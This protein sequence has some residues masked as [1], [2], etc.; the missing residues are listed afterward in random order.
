MASLLVTIDPLNDGKINFSGNFR[1]YTNDEPISNVVSITD[2]LEDV[3]FGDNDPNL[4]KRFFRYSKDGDTWSMWYDWEPFS[5]PELGII[6]LLAFNPDDSLY[7]S[8]KYLYDDGSHDVLLTPIEINEINLKLNLKVTKVPLNLNSIKPKVSCTPEHCPD[9]L[10]DRHSSFD[11]YDIGNLGD[12]YK[13]MSYSINEFGGLPVLYFQTTPNASG[14]DFIFREYTLYDVLDR[15][16]VKVV[17][18]KNE[19]PTADFRFV[20]NGQEYSGPFEVSID[21]LYFETYFGRGKEPRKKDF[22]YFPLLN[23]MYEIQDVSMFR[24]FMMIPIYWKIILTKFQ[25]NINYNLGEQNSKFLDNILLNS[26]NQFGTEAKKQEL[27]VLMEQQNSTISEKYDEVRS[28]IDT[29]MFI[30]E[31]ELNYNYSRLINYYY[32]LTRISTTGDIAVLYKDKAKIGVDNDVTFMFNFQLLNGAGNNI[33]FITT[34]GTGSPSIFDIGGIY[35]SRNQTLQ[36]LANINSNTYTMDLNSIT[37][38][39]WYT[40]IVSISPTYKQVGIY[41]YTYVYDSD[42]TDNITGFNLIDKKLFPIINVNDIVLN[43]NDTFA[44]VKGFLNMSNIRIFNRTI[45]YEMHEFIMSQLFIRDESVLRVIDN[46]RPQI[47][48]PFIMKKY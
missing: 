31:T 20:G 40:C 48:L 41:L 16:C 21:K 13:E 26:D 3:N 44:L 11:P 47:G 24:G 7:F 42:V 29:S 34:N 14:T 28:Y 6:G 37:T 33:K 46:C 9:M 12:F 8:F 17:V 18:N 5:S 23:R 4:V 19:F 32:N 22:L 45:E 36:I 27:N 43:S 1:I 30:G 2:I 25:P 39:K 15:K 38:D 10:F 35:S